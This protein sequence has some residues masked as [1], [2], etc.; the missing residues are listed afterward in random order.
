MIFVFR[1]TMPR[2]SPPS[3]YYPAEDD[4]L[5]PLLDPYCVCPAESRWKLVHYFKNEHISLFIGV[6]AMCSPPSLLRWWPLTNTSD[7]YNRQHPMIIIEVGRRKPLQSPCLHCIALYGETDSSLSDG[8]RTKLKHHHSTIHSN[9]SYNTPP[10]HRRN[11][12][13]Y[14][15]I[16]LFDEIRTKMGE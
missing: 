15:L 9:S 11:D 1:P 10:T 7:A 16:A 3:L 6:C 4:I 2:T 5:E 14:N 8:Q 12:T 13:F